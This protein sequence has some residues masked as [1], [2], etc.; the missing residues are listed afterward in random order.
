MQSVVP[1]VG[2]SK[3]KKHLKNTVLEHN[4]ALKFKLK[5]FLTQF[6]QNPDNLYISL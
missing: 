4:Y 5:K 3:K 1:A 6:L 2:H